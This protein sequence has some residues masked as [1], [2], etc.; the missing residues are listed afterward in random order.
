[1]FHLLGQFLSVEKNE[2]RR[3]VADRPE[4]L[5]TKQYFVKWSQCFTMLDIVRSKKYFT[6]VTKPVVHQWK[7]GY[8]ASKWSSV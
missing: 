2:Q 4:D 7:L 1:M 3:V 6:D 8:R 5:D